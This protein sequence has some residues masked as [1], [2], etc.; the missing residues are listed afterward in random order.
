MKTINKKETL[1]ISLIGMSGSGKS[2][3]SKK[4][5]GKGFRLVC[6]D[7]FIEQDLACEL[8]KHGKGIRNVANW[9]GHPYEKRFKRNQSRY[10]NSE[11]NNM[12]KIIDKLKMG[13]D[14]NVVIDTTGSVIYTGSLIMRSLKKHS[15]VIYLESP[16][17]VFKEMLKKFMEDPKPVIWKDTFS[18]NKN[19]TNEEALRRCYQKLLRQRVKLY[20]KYADVIMRH[21]KRTSPDFTVEDFVLFIE[22]ARKK[23]VSKFPA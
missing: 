10:L 9:M 18:K 1:V 13:V 11:I 21:K 14:E 6:C 17:S 4:L 5:A 7:D 23:I 2:Y 15:L 16:V 12:R 8:K 19:E 3:L 20:K 22:R